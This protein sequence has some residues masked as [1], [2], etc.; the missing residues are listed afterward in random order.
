[1]LAVV[2]ARAQLAGEHDV[3]GVDLNGDPYEGSLTIQQEGAVQWFIWERPLAGTPARYWGSSLRGGD[4]V[5]VAFRFRDDGAS[6]STALYHIN[7][8]TG[9]GGRAVE[10]EGPWAPM[11]SAQAG[12]EVARSR[13]GGLTGQLA[14]RYAVHGEH[15]DLSRYTDDATIEEDGGGVYRMLWETTGVV[16]VGLRVLDHL[17]VAYGGGSCVLM[18]Y[19]VLPDGSLSGTWVT[20]DRAPNSGG[21]T[22]RV[23]RR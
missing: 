9:G 22:E 17:A 6:C 11:G 13:T 15:N 1:V 4:V 7:E 16:G 14:G 12:T 18:A 20:N 2:P 8:Y 19:Q 5:A 3:A 21:G 23:V 10:L